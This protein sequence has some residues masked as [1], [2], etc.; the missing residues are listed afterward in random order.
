MATKLAQ[1][2]FNFILSD[3]ASSVCKLSESGTRQKLI[4]TTMSVDL[5][6]A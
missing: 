4:N 6:H 3:V 1:A 5:R 2:F